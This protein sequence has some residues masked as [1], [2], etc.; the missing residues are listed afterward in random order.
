MVRPALHCLGEAVLYSCGMVEDF[1][2][3]HNE[4]RNPIQ[5][6][7]FQELVAPTL[8]NPLSAIRISLSL[9][10]VKSLSDPS[11][12]GYRERRESWSMWERGAM[13]AYRYHSTPLYSLHEPE[14]E[15][16]WGQGIVEIYPEKLP[17]IGSWPEELRSCASFTL[18]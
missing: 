18:G 4:A 14:S 17:K 7:W 6:I 5:L 9:G 13:A 15:L 2:F 3:V 16:E 11:S 1:S 10:G 12:R 8:V